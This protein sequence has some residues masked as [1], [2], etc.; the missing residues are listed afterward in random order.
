MVSVVSGAGLA[1][2]QRGQP[3]SGGTSDRSPFY[4]EFEG[5]ATF[6]HK[7]SGSLGGEGGYRISRMFDVFIEGGHMKNV[8]TEDVDRRAQLIANFVGATVSVAQRVNYFD[9]AVRY[10]FRQ[11]RA[12]GHVVE[13]YATFGAGLVQVRSDTVFSVNGTAMPP[14]AL[15]I[16]TGN[17]LNGTV[18]KGFIT[19]GA[20]GHAPLGKRYFADL[21]VRYGRILARTSEIENDVGINTTR[22]QLGVGIRFD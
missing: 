4:L 21:S 19:I 7:S 18:K 14:Q 5:G 12:M 11:T 16:Q 10:R 6:G 13:P 15:G 1:Y 9:G 3:T 22:L 8:A 20:G 2:A 17:D